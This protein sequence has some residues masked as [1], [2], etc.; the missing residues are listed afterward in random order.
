MPENCVCA[1]VRVCVCA[2]LD[3]LSEW[4]QTHASGW[5]V[6]AQAQAQAYEE[7]RVDNERGVLG[8]HAQTARGRHSCTRWDK[9]EAVGGCACA[10]GGSCVL[11]MT[12]RNALERSR[13]LYVGW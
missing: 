3:R 13:K 5:T 12:S 9:E 8:H 11:V 10:R 2:T 4:R 6:Q 7:E 1:C